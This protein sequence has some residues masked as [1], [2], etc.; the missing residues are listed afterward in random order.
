MKHGPTLIFLAFAIALGAC[1]SAADNDQPAQV[2]PNPLGNGDRLRDVQDPSNADYAPNKNVNVST[3]VVTA[4]DNF[5]ETHN[6]KSLGTIFVQDADQALPYGGIS[7]YSPTFVPANLRLAPGDVVSMSGEYVEEQTI[8]TTVNFAPNFLP[9]MSKPQVTQ[10]FE[11]QLPAPVEVTLDQLSSFATARP[12][13]G[14][15]VV[16]KDVTAPY[17]PS[18]S[19]SSGRITADL[20]S[21]VDGPAIN[22]ELWDLQAWNGSNSSNSFPAGTHFTSITGIVDFFFNIFIAPRSAADLVQGP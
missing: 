2:T 12:Y 17:A 20:T 5:D 3:V 16:L 10:D 15:L 4:V 22:N 13:I 14:M 6:G 11:T 18:A 9:Q 21:I 7:L 19:D 8:G 1:S